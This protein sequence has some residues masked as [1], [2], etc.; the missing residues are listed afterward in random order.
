M[1]INSAHLPAHHADTSTY[2]SAQTKANSPLPTSSSSPI[3]S[4]LSYLPY[5]SFL[6]FLSYSLL[7]SQNGFRMQF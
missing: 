2:H 6:S 1:M 5:L 3:S 4:Y 7:S